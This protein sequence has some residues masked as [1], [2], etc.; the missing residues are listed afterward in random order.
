MHD[1]KRPRAEIDDGQFFIQIDEE[2]AQEGN[3]PPVDEQLEQETDNF[4]AEEDNEEELDEQ[5]PEEELDKER[6]KAPEEELDKKPEEK[7]DKQE[8]EGGSVQKDVAELHQPPLILGPGETPLQRAL[9]KSKLSWVKID[10]LSQEDQQKLK[11]GH[12]EHLIN[13]AIRVRFPG[14]DTYKKL[15]LPIPSDDSRE[16]TG[17]KPFPIMLS[18]CISDDELNI[19]RCNIE[20][21][22]KFDVHLPWRATEGED[23][24][25]WFLV[26]IGTYIQIANSKASVF[27]DRRELFDN[28]TPDP[29]QLSHSPN[30][31]RFMTRG[32]FEAIF[33]WALG[34]YDPKKP[35]D[36]IPKL[37][38]H[39][40]YAAFAWMEKIDKLAIAVDEII[41]PFTG[42]EQEK[43]MV[44]LNQ[45]QDAA[46]SEKVYIMGGGGRGE[47]Y[48]ATHACIKLCRG[49]Y[50]PFSLY[51]EFKSAPFNVELTECERDVMGKPT[52]QNPGRG[53][54]Q[55][56]FF[57]V[58]QK[59]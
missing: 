23:F 19:I 16:A 6:D 8:G 40:S 10:E 18:M 53:A 27:G 29:L 58:S 14:V 25:I 49:S 41:L 3:P 48:W 28:Y 13:D 34:S 54:F 4:Q 22:E 50:A 15:R 5:E 30:L 51:L 39:Y 43:H 52:P 12:Y 24:R 2:K 20:E 33:G 35:W 59:N 9:K 32:C 55:R 45:F 36:Q 17:T 42:R 1:L 38:L 21:N 46:P 7:V 26:F 47:G 57:E 56:Y 31:Q 44:K 37:F 11:M